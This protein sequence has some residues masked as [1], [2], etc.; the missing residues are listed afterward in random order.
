[1][2]SRDGITWLEY[3]KNQEICFILFYKYYYNL[4]KYGY[5]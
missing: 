2:S 4:K 5:I 3:Y 1:M